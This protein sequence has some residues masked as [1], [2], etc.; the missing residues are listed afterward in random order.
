MMLVHAF[1]HALKAMRM[2]LL[3]SHLQEKTKTLKEEK[4][5]A[6]CSSSKVTKRYKELKKEKTE[7]AKERK[8]LYQHRKNLEK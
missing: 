3:V 4:K 1:S 8:G 6:E 7:W 5:E 2:A